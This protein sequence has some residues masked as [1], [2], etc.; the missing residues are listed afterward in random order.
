M[1]E[2]FYKGVALELVAKL[3]RL[4]A[5]TGHPG[6]V[7][8]HHEEVVREAIRPLLSARFSLRTGFLCAEPGAASRQCDILIVDENDPSPYL[9]RLGDLVV[10]QPRAV[11]A[12]IEVKTN[13]RKADFHSALCTL[14][15]ARDVARA[16]TPEGAFMTLIFAFEGVQFV[17]NTMDEWFRSAAVPDDVYSYPQSIFVL[18]EGLLHLKRHGARFGMHFVM[19]EEDDDLKTRSLSLFLQGVRKA[20]ETHAGLES[21]PFEFADIRELRLSTQYLRIGVG[22]VDPTAVT[23]T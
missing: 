16:A 17:V 20:L 4:T 6:S 19:G 15:S 3:R 7:G 9:F 11:A 8:W 21:N 1:D 10:V 13:L 18:Q 22:G 23:D 2:E 5:F 12:I 14:R